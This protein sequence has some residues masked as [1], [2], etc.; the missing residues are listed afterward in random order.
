MKK[1]N[2]IKSSVILIVSVAVA[3]A[4]GAFFRIP[5]ANMLGGNGMAYFSGAYGIFLPVY[6]VFVTGLSSA[7]AKL[8]AEYTAL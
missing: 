1:Q 8:T 2:F 7:S 4:A 6:A 5:L 3:K